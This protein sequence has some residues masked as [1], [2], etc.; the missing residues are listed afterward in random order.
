M[1]QMQHDR[2]LFTQPDGTH[3]GESPLCSLQ[4]PIDGS[5]SV[6]YTCCSETICYGCICANTISNI[7]DE[8]KALR[9]PFCRKLG[10]SGE[11]NDKR[12]MKRVEANDPAALCHMGKKYY[13][14]GDYEGAFEYYTKAA[15]LEGTD[16]HAQLGWM[17]E[18]GQGV[19]KDEEKSIYHHEKA[20]IGGHP[21][22]RN[23]LAC[24]EEDNGNIERAVKHLIIAANLGYDLSMKA[25][26]KHYSAGNITKEDLDA[27]LRTHQAAVN[28]TKS[29]QRDAAEVALQG[30][31]EWAGNI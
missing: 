9:C 17:Y 11:E 24:K 4:L 31:D 15:E 14:E 22:A 19:E 20:A 2:T 16:A 12:N 28:E 21:I 26:W 29:A 6:F 27:T 3:H 7:H 25:L 1:K 18:R 30:I 5:K 8:T 10:V 23:M 13:H